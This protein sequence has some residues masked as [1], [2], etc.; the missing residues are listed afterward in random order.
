[1]N[2][3]IRVIRRDI[4]A[5]RRIL[6]TSDIH[7]NLTHLE[8][9]LEKAD[10]GKYDI[11]V[12]VG[13][14]IEKGPQSLETLRYVMRLCENENVIVLA[15]NVDLRRAQ[16]IME[17][18]KETAD[19]FYKYLLYMRGWK[20]TSIYDEM[21]AECGITLSCPEDILVAN[22]VITA[23][24]RRELDF[25]LDRPTVLET[26]NYIFVHGGLPQKTLDNIESYNIYELLKYDNFMATDTHF[27]KYIVAGHWPVT[28]YGE[29]IPQ[30]DPLINTEKKII[31]IDGGCGLKEDG[32]LNLI[33]IPDISCDVSGIITHTYHEF[34]TYT[35]LDS[36]TASED[37]VNISWINNEIKEI[38]TKDDFTYAEHL[39][40]GRRLWIY[41]DFIYK[42]HRCNDCTDYILPVECGDMI[43]VV[44]TTSRGY[45][46]K[47]DG[48]TGWYYGRL[49]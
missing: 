35:A 5:G 2:N 7:G 43:S 34:P 49:G 16:I 30:S 4:E 29:K 11:L 47:K 6:V 28:L 42:E 31:S 25:L 45:I 32:Q 22:P 37:S 3:K 36:Q 24:F 44:R 18:N 8:G 15:G 46:A 9:V 39:Q 26:Q 20:G 48:V 13:D 33:E 10:Y 40:T 12:I 41:N 17:I 19:S 38:E 14:I 23:R 27:D 21:A 1:M